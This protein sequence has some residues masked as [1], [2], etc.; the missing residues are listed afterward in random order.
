MV[1]YVARDDQ[2]L[3][4]PNRPTG[5]SGERRSDAAE[6]GP[7][8][9]PPRSDVGTIV[10]HWVTAVAFFVSILTGVRIAADDPD[11]VVS[12]WLAPIT[13]QG[14]LWTWHFFAGLTLFF[15]A[16]GY[17]LYMAR[18]GLAPRI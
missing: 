14:E 9:G 2:S 5:E 7:R 1:D 17:I 12:K 13:P 15:C 10:L 18:S 8:T 4:S 3:A 16:S 11:A 6:R